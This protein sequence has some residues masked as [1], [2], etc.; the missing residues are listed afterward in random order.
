MRAVF[1]Y[2]AGKLQL[3]GIPIPA[4][5]EGLVLLKVLAC[6]I[7]GGEY[8]MLLRPPGTVPGTEGVIPGHE[9]IGE[10]VASPPGLFAIGTRVAVSPNYSCGFCDY[11][12]SG[13]LYLCANRP[14]RTAEIGGGYADYCLVHPSQ[15]YTLPENLEPLAAA[16]TETLACC[17]HGAAKVDIQAG[18]KVLII[19][20]GANAQLFVQIARLRGAA[21]VMVVD[22]LQDRMD[23]ALALG[24]DMA[25][26]ADESDPLIAS[27]LL[28]YGADVVIV[29][30]GKA[31]AV[32]DAVN[33]CASGGRVL[34]YGVAL[35]GIPA[36]IEPHSLWKK[37]VSV[38][39]SR[40][41]GSSFGTA[42]S[43]ISAGRINVRPIITRTVPLDGVID[44][45]HNPQSSIKTVIVPQPTGME[46]AVG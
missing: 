13:Y 43:L 39:G 35:P 30:R 16:I 10:V 45:L 14:K 23:M 31:E 19:G 46:D 44:A 36:L 32:T 4:P 18:D 11:C 2:G 7:C 33:W 42:L 41:Y 38:V 15:C 27:P 8:K 5:A 9:I 26:N 3:E 25:V 28:K 37:E 29:N 6:G 1:N 21:F 20:A 22:N 34:C 12:R 40:S 17:L 24:A